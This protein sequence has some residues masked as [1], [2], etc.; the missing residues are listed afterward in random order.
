MH[1]DFLKMSMPPGST[2]TTYITNIHHAAYHLE[3]S[4]QAEQ[5]DSVSLSTITSPSISTIR[6]PII[7]DLDKI[8]I[9]LNGLP[10]AYQPV[11]TVKAWSWGPESEGIVVGMVAGEMLWRQ[12]SLFIRCVMTSSKVSEVRG[13]PVILSITPTSQLKGMSTPFRDMSKVKC[14]KCGRVGH[15]CS[16]HQQNVGTDICI[17]NGI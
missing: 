8:S 9:L 15:I 3:E 6:F 11:G 7:L 5:D 17:Y 13:M 4:Y 10:P 14:H 2:I 1:M 16:Y 12:P